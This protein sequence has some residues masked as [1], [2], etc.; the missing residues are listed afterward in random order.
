MEKKFLKVGN[1]INFK[2]NTDGLEYDLIPGTVYNIIVDSYTD[3]VSLQE[4]GKLPLPSKVYC[5]SRD[6]RFIDK[7]VNSYNLSESGFTGVM[8]AGLKGSGKTV[9]AKMIA[10]KSGLPIVNIDKTYV[11]ISFEILQRCSVTQVFASCLMSLTK[12]L[13]ITMI[14]SY[15]RYWMVLILRVSI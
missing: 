13:Q 10:N 5:T 8:L 11:H 2:F 1:N 7:V 6:E 9:M 4:S 15:Y 3:T 12:F 14:L